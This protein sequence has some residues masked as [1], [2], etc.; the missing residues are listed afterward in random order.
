MP[1]KLAPVP[2]DTDHATLCPVRDVMDRIGDRWSCLILLTLAHGTHRFTELQRAIGDISK[3]M[4]AQTLRTLEQDGYLTRKVHPVVP[5]MVEYALS[6]LGESLVGHIES[7]F[8]WADKHHD[9][10]R[11]ARK[12]YQPPGVPTPTK[13][14]ED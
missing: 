1:I 14:A 8:R 5:P 13:W 4:L 2:P 10:V 7:L 6:P 11:K 3:R 9:H 12:R